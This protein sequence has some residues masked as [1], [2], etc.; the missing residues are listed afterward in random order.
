MDESLRSERDRLAA[1]AESGASE[2]LPRA[3]QLLRAAREQGRAATI[4]VARAICGAQ[5]SMASFWNAAA[6]ALADEAQPGALERFELRVKRGR[7]ALTRF[8]VDLLVPRAIESSGGDAGP[9]TSA[10]FTTF[11]FSGSVLTAILALAERMAVTI[12]CAEGRPRMEGRR[13]A[14]ALARAGIAVEFYT[15]AGIGSI[16]AES[17]ALL[18][19]ADAITPHGFANKVG[20]A[21]L[22][23]TAA[24]AGVPVFVLA[25]RDKF[26]PPRLAPALSI[27]DHAPSE[28]WETPPHGV[29]V[30]NPYFERVPLDHVTGIVTDA[31]VLGADMVEEACRANGVWVGEE[32]LAALAP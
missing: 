32:A 1:D 29:A 14:D 17:D 18:I 16:V 15:D 4:E 7:P 6:A 28:V 13:L 11:S 30:R 8:A 25:G 10:H 12:A 31:G 27:D 26:L 22:A 9:T 20:T 3:I 24:W 19:G 2:L 21:Q 23:A 5:P